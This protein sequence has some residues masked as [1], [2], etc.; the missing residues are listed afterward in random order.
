MSELADVCRSV[1]LGESHPFALSDFAARAIQMGRP[2]D[3]QALHMPVEV[4][5]LEIRKLALCLPALRAFHGDCRAFL[6]HRLKKREQ[7]IEG[8][9]PWNLVLGG[10]ELK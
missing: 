7:D 4:L 8:S 1:L 10:I 9:I 5:E 6:A 2:V 3:P